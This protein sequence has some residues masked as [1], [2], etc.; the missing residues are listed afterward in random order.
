[1][2]HFKWF[3]T[4][5]S[6]Y[7]SFFETLQRLNSSRRCLISLNWRVNVV[8]IFVLSSSTRFSYHLSVNIFQLSLD[9]ELSSLYSKKIV[10]FSHQMVTKSNCPNRSAFLFTQNT[11]ELFNNLILS[12]VLTAQ[13]SFS[14][15][16]F[17]KTLFE[18]NMCSSN[19]CV[20]FWI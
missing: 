4:D 1:M 2:S 5:E 16:C 3:I 15:V 20:G 18:K 19:M 14:N 8:C 6:V 17:S 9:D 7:F 11:A 12:Q 10:Q 13:V